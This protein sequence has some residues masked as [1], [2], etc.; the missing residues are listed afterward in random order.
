M[1]LLV[2]YDSEIEDKWRDS[3]LKAISSNIPDAEFFAVKTGKIINEKLNTKNDRLLLVEPL[4]EGVKNQLLAYIEEKPELDIEGAYTDKLTI[5]A[6]AVLKVLKDVKGK[7]IAILNQSKVLGK[8][9]AIELIKQG[10]NVHSLNS[11]GDLFNIK[12]ANWLITATGDKNFQFAKKD[13]KGFTRII[14]LSEDTTLKKS[15]RRVP[16][17][18]ALKS[19]LEECQAQIRKPNTWG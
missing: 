9:L 13:L 1:R 11:K 4:T 15:I 6:E 12:K 5:T 18:E 10:A 16:T 3:Y 14:D 17:I 19:R 8:S 2:F 7:E